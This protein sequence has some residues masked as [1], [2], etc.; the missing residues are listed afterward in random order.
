MAML[1]ARPP[2][3]TISSRVGSSIPRL[4]AISGNDLTERPPRKRLAAIDRG[5]DVVDGVPHLLAAF[6]MLHAVTGDD[7]PPMGEI[8]HRGRQPA[9]E[10]FSITWVAQRLAGNVLSD[11]G[12][13]AMIAAGRFSPPRAEARRYQRPGISCPEPR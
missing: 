3:P 6:G 12:S 11:R 10:T 1:T 4:A 2:G 9:V 8:L 7:P 13:G 5:L